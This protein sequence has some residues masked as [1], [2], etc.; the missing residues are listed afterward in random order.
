MGHN[1]IK[2]SLPDDLQ[3]ACHN[4]SNSCT[5]TGPAESVNVY[6]QKLQKE[7]VFARAVNVANIA[8]HSKWIKAAGPKLLHRLQKVRLIF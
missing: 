1:Q 4:S 8:Y 5:I 2:D 3:V 6:I 7:G